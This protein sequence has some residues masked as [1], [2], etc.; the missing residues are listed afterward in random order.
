[1]NRQRLIALAVTF[2]V[3]MLLLGL[4]LWLRIQYSPPVKK[5]SEITLVP[6]GVM[7]SASASASSPSS[8]MAS[9]AE[10]PTRSVPTPPQIKTPQ[11]T[12]D[13]STAPVAAPPKNDR[14][15]L[16][17]REEARQA[18]ERRK[19]ESQM[20][21][22]FKG[23]GKNNNGH[24]GAEGTGTSSQVGAGY[25]LEGRDI[26]DGGRPAMP[27]GFSPVRGTIVVRITVDSEGRV[28][29]ARHQLQG[30]NIT[31][32]NAITAA[33]RAAKQTRFSSLP[34]AAKQVGTITYHFDIQ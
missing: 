31:Q 2:V 23:G 9:K 13:K 34:G 22:A 26:L 12:S 30:S 7:A 10:L 11:T 33:I 19:I 27:T 1:M 24:E 14:A 18:E 16:Q 25:S 21:G 4:L 28:V 29:D 6:V 15:E 32:Q 5:V 3:H 8:S 17:R 20:K